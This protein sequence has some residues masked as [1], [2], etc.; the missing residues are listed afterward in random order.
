[1]MDW[2]ESSVLNY[3]NRVILLLHCQ[4]RNLRA[5]LGGSP[6]LHWP[7]EWAALGGPGSSAPALHLPQP[8]SLC[9]PRCTALWN[10]YLSS[11]G[12]LSWL[13]VGSGGPGNSVETSLPWQ[14]G[15]RE[16]TGVNFTSIVWISRLKILGVFPSS[17]ETSILVWSNL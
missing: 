9:R 16:K 7:V 4:E 6:Q 11:L 2:T 13:Q 3:P 5:P 1:M 8:Q 10:L 12:M 15:E 14:S 17:T